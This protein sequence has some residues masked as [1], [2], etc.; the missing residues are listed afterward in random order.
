M[1]ERLSELDQQIRDTPL[2]GLMIA[3]D[4]NKAKRNACLIFCLISVGLVLFL[5]WNRWLFLLPALLGV[6]ALL[7]HMNIVIVTAEVKRRRKESG[8]EHSPE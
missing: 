8:T 2:I 4:E 1:S 6:G 5:A 3:I 7:Y